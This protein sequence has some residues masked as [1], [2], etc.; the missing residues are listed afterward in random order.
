MFG[1]GF[2]QNAC[3]GGECVSKALLFH[4]VYVFVHCASSVSIDKFTRF[5][6]LLRGG[7]TSWRSLSWS[8]SLSVSKSSDPRP[9]WNGMPWSVKSSAFDMG[10]LCGW[11]SFVG[12]R[13]LG[14]SS[15]GSRSA[16]GSLLACLW[17]ISCWLDCLF[18]LA[19][20]FARDSELITFN[21]TWCLPAHCSGGLY[22]WPLM[23]RIRIRL[24][25][26]HCWRSVREGW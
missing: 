15:F 26:R 1:S 9:G 11:F 22:P 13:L 23:W 14:S 21:V 7:D 16:F 8:L 3:Q 4:R 17:K 20:L 18:V 24:L 25:R 12:E 10:R 2:V 19:M 5:V 6:L